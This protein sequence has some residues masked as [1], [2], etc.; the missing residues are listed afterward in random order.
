M[1]ERGREAPDGFYE[2]PEIAS[3]LT[4]IWDAFWEFGTER[5]FGMT[6]RADPRIEDPGIPARRTGID[7]DEYDRARA[8][9][10]KADDAYV[11]C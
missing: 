10:R 8:I 4:L 5:Q 6:C 9:I 2:R 3:H 1:A 7:G 11:A